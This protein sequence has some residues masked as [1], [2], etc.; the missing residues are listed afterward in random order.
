MTAP[1]TPANL[2]VLVVEDE[3]LI[4]FMIEDCLL[5]FGHRVV[6]PASRVGAAMKL[7]EDVE[8]DLALLDINVAGEQIYPVAAELKARGVPFIFLSGYGSAG[9]HADWA[10]AALIEKPFAP[11]ALKRGIAHAMAPAP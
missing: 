4:A 3:M 8:L 7:V 10:G 11:D 9:L 6:G 1:E 5:Q 2:R